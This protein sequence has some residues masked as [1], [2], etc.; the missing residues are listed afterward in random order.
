MSEPGTLFLTGA[1]SHTGSHVAR[2]LLADGWRLRCLNHDPA[3]AGYLPQDERLEILPGDLTRPGDAWAA[4]L[5]GASACIHMAH[6]GYGAQIAAACAAAGVRRVIALSSTRRFTRFPEP[7]ARL[8]IEGEA[9]LAASDLDYT[10]LRATMIFGG[11]RDNNL[12]KIVRWL[13]RCRWMPLVAG[14][15]NLV[16]PIFVLDLVEAVVRTLGRPDATR[17]RALTIAGPEPMTQRAM[18]EAVGR[19][20]DRPVRWVPVP[21]G[22]YYAAAGV[23]ECIRS[24]R[25]PPQPR[26]GAPHARRQSL[27]HHR[28]RRDA[29]RVAAAA[30]HR[31]PRAQDRRPGLNPQ[32]GSSTIPV[33]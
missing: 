29:G 22:L 3:R 2:R 15:R 27:R 8:V 20:L 19:A 26:A 21:Y 7:T 33:D 31:S 13:Q 12:E 1:T 14:G 9:A 4:R 10:I 11:P 6:V 25:P 16:Q 24:R 32:R 30:L 23:A 5:E 28:G 17:C 18:I